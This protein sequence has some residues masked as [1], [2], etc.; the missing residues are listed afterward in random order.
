[1]STPRVCLFLGFFALLMVGVA[2]AIEPAQAQPKSTP[3]KVAVIDLR[4]VFE[5]YEKFATSK[6]QLLSEAKARRDE[7]EVMA[8]E[9]R[10]LANSLDSISESD[11]RQRVQ[12]EIA[13]RRAQ[14]DKVSSRYERSIHQQEA[15]MYALAY[16]ELSGLLEQF[17]THHGI[18]IV[19]RTGTVIGENRVDESDPQ[20]VRA[21][22]QRQIVYFVPELDI[23]DAVVAELNQRN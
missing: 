1:M 22:I 15:Q 21:H 14:F 13:D 19:L 12:D 20:S 3:T 16:A 5:R 9:A 17:C 10:E 11:V 18:A 6:Q 4:D 8:T 7:L 2:L 23:T